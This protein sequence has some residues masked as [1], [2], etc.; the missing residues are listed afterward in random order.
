M[1]NPYDILGVTP[2]DTKDTI[3]KRYKKLALLYHP[4]RN[5]SDSVAACEK[6][7]KIN[8]AYNLLY[9]DKFDS[10]EEYFKSFTDKLINKGKFFGDFL[11]NFDKTKFKTT[12]FTELKN[13]KTF[14]EHVN[15][16]E[17]TD[18]ININVNIE[19]E[20]IYKNIEKMTDI[21]VNEQCDDC[22]IND[23][24]ICPICDTTGIIVKTKTIVFNSGEKITIHSGESNYEPNKKQGNIIINVIPKLHSN[25]RILNNYDILYEIIGDETSIMVDHTFNYLNGQ[26]HKFKANSPYKNEY[27]IEGMGLLIPYLDYKRG[28]LII[29]IKILTKHNNS[30]DQYDY[31]FM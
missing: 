16:N 28:D 31:D 3:K 4:D 2:T 30:A 17:Y 6:F 12:L 19:L 14:Y 18:D 27:I 9:N 24:K 10:G 23:L 11:K 22:I 7:K 20:D 13:Y 29:Q 8:S 21:E 15:T 26:Q 25:F 5:I 1:E